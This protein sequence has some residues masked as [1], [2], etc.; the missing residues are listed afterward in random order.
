MRSFLVRSQETVRNC[1]LETSNIMKGNEYDDPL[2]ITGRISVCSETTK[3]LKE[4]APTNIVKNKYLSHML[5][6]YI[7]MF[8]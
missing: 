3:N 2:G 5:M 4:Y 1:N 8:S 7:P 6:N